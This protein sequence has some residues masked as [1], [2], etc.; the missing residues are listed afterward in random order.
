MSASESNPSEPAREDT[1]AATGLFSWWALRLVP[2]RNPAA[3]AGYY[4]GIMALFP[5]L[6]F[7]LAPG[8]LALGVY[9]RKQIRLDPSVDGKVHATIAIGLAVFSLVIQPLLTIVL[10]KIWE[11]EI[12]MYFHR[13]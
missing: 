8:A 6:G 9:A 7:F 12:R 4:F 5:V 3:V 10:W 11:Y 1:V 2:L 13:W